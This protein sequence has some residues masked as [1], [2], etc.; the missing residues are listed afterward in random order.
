MTED[1]ERQ[2]DELIAAGNKAT[3]GEWKHDTGAA[4]KGQY[5]VVLGEDHM[6]AEFYEGEEEGQGLDATFITQAANSREALKA[7]RDERDRLREELSVANCAFDLCHR[8]NGN[9]KSEY[10]EEAR[11]GRNDEGS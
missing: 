4:F 6:I 1:Q 9:R 2:I 11:K 3:Q 10:F 7:L 8:Y 5:H